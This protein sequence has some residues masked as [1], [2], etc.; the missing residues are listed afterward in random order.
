MPTLSYNVALG[1]SSYERY[2]RYFLLEFRY[3]ETVIIHSLQYF[4]GSVS[5]NRSPSPKAVKF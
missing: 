3:L 4:I 5:K 2:G 1:K